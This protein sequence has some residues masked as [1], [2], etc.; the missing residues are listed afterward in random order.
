MKRLTSWLGFHGNPCLFD[1]GR[2]GERGQQRAGQPDVPVL[3]QRHADAEDVKR[4]DVQV[5]LR[6]ESDHTVVDEE[7]DKKNL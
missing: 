5:R 6:R 2:L 4:R 7:E 1:P 3:R